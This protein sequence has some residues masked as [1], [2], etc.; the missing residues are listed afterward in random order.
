MRGFHGPGEIFHIA[1]PSPWVGI[2]GA[3]EDGPPS[4]GNEVVGATPGG[5]GSGTGQQP[6]DHGGKRVLI[7]RGYRSATGPDL[8]RRTG[9]GFRM[10]PLPLNSAQ[11]A[12]V[13]P[14]APNVDD[15]FLVAQ[16]RRGAQ[17]PVHRSFVVYGPER[18]GDL[19]Q[20][21]EHAR[22]RMRVSAPEP[23]AQ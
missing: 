1:E 20:E 9:E 7:T 4:I 3:C 22:R 5:R 15:G 19:P 8:G 14:E 17:G 21:S 2:E 18:L 6:S 16:E 12:Q 10:A 23:M 11:D 13:D